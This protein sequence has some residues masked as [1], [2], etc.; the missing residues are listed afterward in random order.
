VK[1][2]LIQEIKK[3]QLMKRM[4]ASTLLLCSLM[5]SGCAIG[6]T[7]GSSA[8]LPAA[9]QEEADTPEPV[10]EPVSAS[11]ASANTP[12]PVE[13]SVLAP[14]AAS[15]N[16]PEPVEEPVPAPAASANTPEPVEESVPA[17]A[18]ASANTPEPVEESAPAP[19]AASANTPAIPGGWDVI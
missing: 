11:A 6:L 3:D 5:I 12:E 17:P 15:A 9:V 14:D 16:T 2:S 7:S 18:A 8:P 13:E 1:S 10:E 19:A 4:I